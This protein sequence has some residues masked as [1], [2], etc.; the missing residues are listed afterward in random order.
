M[1]E[2]QL[3]QGQVALVDDA[4]H[5]WLS[6]RKWYAR[7]N[8]YTRSFYAM[9]NSSRVGGKRKT[10]YMHRE[11]LACQPG[12]EGDHVHSGDTLNNQRYNLRACTKF[13]NQQNQR[14]Q[15]GRS[16]IY[17]GVSWYKAGGKWMAYIGF[18]GR[19]QHLGYFDDEMVA[20]IARD[21]KAR[22]LHGEFALL[23]FPDRTA[24]IAG[25][26]GFVAT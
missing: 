13:Q 22:E 23:N 11:I 1:K 20:A 16:S 14:P 25:F 3:S 5:D 21:A 18:E 2:I 9:R 6:L 17:K 15:V 8:P 12:Q 24:D 19:L 10:L 7:W 26:A 4:D